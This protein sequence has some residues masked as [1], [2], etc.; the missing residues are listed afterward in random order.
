MPL[1]QEYFDHDIERLRAVIGE[2]FFETV[3]LPKSTS[4]LFD[5][6]NQKLRLKK[7]EDKELLDVLMS[8]AE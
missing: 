3:T 6:E 4:D 1:L 7:L 8:V 5:G 2:D